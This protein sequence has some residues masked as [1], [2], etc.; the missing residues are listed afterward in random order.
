MSRRPFKRKGRKGWTV[1]REDGKQRS[2]PKKEDAED[3]AELQRQRQRAGL[4]LVSDL[5]FEQYALLWLKRTAKTVK[6][7]TAEQY[8]W[9]LE[10]YL[11]PKFGDMKLYQEWTSAFERTGG[12]AIETGNILTASLAAQA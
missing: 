9:A 12:D 2:F 10:H 7:R 4:G 5:T 6:T 8:A 3:W 11:I 1:E